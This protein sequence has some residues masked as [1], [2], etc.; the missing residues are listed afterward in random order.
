M[1]KIKKN[2]SNWGQKLHLEIEDQLEERVFNPLPEKETNDLWVWPIIDKGSWDGPKQDWENSHKQVYFRHIREWNCVVTAGANMGLHVRPYSKL[3]KHVYAF[4]PDWL[5]FYCMSINNPYPNVYKY[6][7]ALGEEP[8]FCNLVN[9]CPDNRGATMINKNATETPI[10]M[11]TIDQFNLPFCDLI[12]LD[13]EGFEIHALKGAIKTIERYKPVIIVER[14][15]QQIVDL[16][17][18]FGYHRHEP[19]IADTVISIGEP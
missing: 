12:Q 3:F 9:G 6:Q 17:S 10:A 19:S 11:M 16:L 5:N 4:E 18:P 14:M 1:S 13:V 2:Q 7:A 15:N 8:G